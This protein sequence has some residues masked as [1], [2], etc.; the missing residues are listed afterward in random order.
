MSAMRTQNKKKGRSRSSNAEQ[1]QITLRAFGKVNTR[2]HTLVRRMASAEFT[3]STTAGGIISSQ[4]IGAS[5]NA[6][7]N[8]PD[9]ASAAGMYQL[10]RVRAIKVQLF[11]LWP[12]PVW[13]GASITTAPAYACVSPF[14]SNFGVTS[15]QGHLDATDMK[16]ISGYKG[17]TFTTQYKGDPEAHFWTPVNTAVPAGESFG[18]VMQGTSTA[19]T[20]SIVIWRAVGWYLVEFKMAS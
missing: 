2:Q 14:Y 13:N 3:I 9:F 19:S 1:Q 20:A 4:S 15:L 6:Y 7:T 8:C 16:L 11:P 18:L 10:Y 5:T 12:I 17:G